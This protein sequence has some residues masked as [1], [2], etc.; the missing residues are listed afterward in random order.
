MA[1]E[2]E[3]SPDSASPAPGDMPQEYKGA[4]FRPSDAPYGSADQLRSLADGYFGLN[5]VFLANVGLVI[6]IRIVTFLEIDAD[7]ATLLLIASL[8]ILFAA[9]FFLSLPCNRKIVFGKGWPDSGAFVASLLM[10]LN[11]VLCCGVVGY[12]VMQQIAVVEMKKYGIHAGFL[13]IRKR[14]VHARVEQI[15]A[16][17]VEAP[18][19]I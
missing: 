5:W 16:S 4:Y 11:S 12:V 2:R 8:A 1:D 18:F 17:S 7:L 9:V 14:D 10:A 19:Q 13:G 3:S 6:A 15:R